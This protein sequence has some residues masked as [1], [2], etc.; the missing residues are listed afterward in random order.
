M[1]NSRGQKSKIQA[2][3]YC[4]AYLDLL[5]Q[6]E[7]LEKLRNLPE[8]ENDKEEFQNYLTKSVGKLEF[9]RYNINQI[10][11]GI[12][13]SPFPNVSGLSSKQITKL[14]NYKSYKIKK[15]YISD[16]LIYYSS[17]AELPNKLPVLAI[18]SI[19]STI[20][21]TLIIG[22]ANKC[23]FRGGIEAGIGF[24][25]FPNEI[26]GPVLYDAY[27]LE[28]KV[29]KYPRI[30]IGN[31]LLEYLIKMSENQG[32]NIDAI[33]S[34]GIAQKCLNMMI[35][36]I[37]GVYILD[38]LGR[39]V[40]SPFDGKYEFLSQL[41]TFIFQGKSFIE[42]EYSLFLDKNENKLAERYFL[43]MTY[44]QHR[45]KSFWQ[46]VLQSTK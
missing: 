26:Y 17:M 35:R 5:N 39:E 33:I 29:C 43:L 1:S 22:I 40:Q 28:N 31:T 20:A 32:N 37:D 44:Y 6:R 14:Q 30:T 2:S 15:Q 9:I 25:F 4:L 38:Y 3:Y 19:L 18:H 36:D 34:K 24:E 21:I 45:Y 7:A 12:K 42:K 13:S 41:Q 11:K 46:N 8:N 16:T 10:L 27:E 23:V